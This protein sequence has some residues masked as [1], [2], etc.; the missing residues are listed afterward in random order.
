MMGLTELI[1]LVFGL[2][3]ADNRRTF[4]VTEALHYT[5]MVDLLLLLLFLFLL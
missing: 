3:F 2:F 1:N 5:L 4:I